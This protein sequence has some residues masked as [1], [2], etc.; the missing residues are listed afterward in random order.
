MA[1]VLLGKLSPRSAAMHEIQRDP[2]LQALT[3]ELIEKALIKIQKD[4][5]ALEEMLFSSISFMDRVDAAGI[6]RTRTARD[7]GIT[8]LAARASGIALD[9]RKI[10]PD[11]Y[12]SFSFKVAKEQ[13]GD[14]AARLKVRCRETKES[15]DIIKQC[16]EKLL[17]CAPSAKTAVQEKEGVAIGCAEAWRGPVLVWTRLDP[18]GKIERCKIVDPSFHNWEGLS[19]AVLGNIIPDFPLCNKSFDLSYPGNDL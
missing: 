5:A 12:N 13:A 7:L 9:T 11:I 1:F 16:L 15:M 2:P 19:F 4:L 10:F 17:L 14:A 6:L 8:G 3:P 18:G